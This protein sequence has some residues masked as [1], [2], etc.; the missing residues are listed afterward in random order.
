M[1][2]YYL[3]V[4]LLLWCLQMMEMLPYLISYLADG[5]TGI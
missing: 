1:Y 4:L 2:L 3:I 5:N